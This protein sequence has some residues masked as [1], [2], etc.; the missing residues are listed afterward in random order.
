MFVWAHN[1]RELFFLNLATYEVRVAEFSTTAESFQREGVTALF[2]APEGSLAF[3]DAL[4][5]V[6][7]VA[8]DDNRFLM[9]RLVGSEEGS[10]S[11]IL[12]LNFFEELK[13]R[14]GAGG[15]L[16][17]PQERRGGQDYGRAS[18]ACC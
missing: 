16:R 17:R 1:G 7:D 12:V 8:P 11:V 18:R 9:T 3:S 14:E 5:R 10:A 6:Y 2:R 4:A 13:E 15:G